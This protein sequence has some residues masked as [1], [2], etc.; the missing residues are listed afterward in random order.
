MQAPE[1]QRG[2]A[3][4]GPG[5]GVDFRFGRAYRESPMS[6]KKTPKVT[7]N[8]QDKAPGYILTAADRAKGG[9]IKHEK[10]AAKKSSEEY[11]K[12]R[13]DELTKDEQDKTYV[14]INSWLKEI[15]ES[16]DGRALL[17]LK[18]MASDSVLTHCMDRAFGK[19]PAKAADGARR[20]AVSEMPDED[21]DRILATNEQIKAA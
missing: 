8:A 19:T 17:R 5:K 9:V 21:L 16:P 18:M 1:R 14:D 4:A 11:I 20:P 15:F 12:G 7:P 6:T 10:V 13:L 3:G 2:G